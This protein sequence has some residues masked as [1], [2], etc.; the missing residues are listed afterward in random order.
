MVN[1]IYLG[2]ILAL[3]FSSCAKQIP[4]TTINLTIKSDIIKFKGQG[5][6][7]DNKGDL[8]LDLYTLGKYINTFKINEKICFNNEC[9][10]KKSFNEKFFGKWYYDDLLKDIILCK[11]IFS[12]KNYSKTPNGFTQ[13]IDDLTYVVDDLKC[14]FSSKNII[15][16]IN[17]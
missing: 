14:E 17:K 7:K 3:F 8:S 15:I 16:K 2:L 9:Y 4:T 5:F 1:K 12:K 13:I 6:L 11:N 10:T